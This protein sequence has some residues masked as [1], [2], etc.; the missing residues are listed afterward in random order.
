MEELEKLAKETEFLAG[1]VRGLVAAQT[2]TPRTFAGLLLDLELAALARALRGPEASPIE[3]VS[4]SMEVVTF[5]DPHH[6]RR[7]VA[8]Q[9]LRNIAKLR[10]PA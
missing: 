8:F 7:Q 1:Y 10:F 3:S 5:H 6:G 9:T 2:E 4:R